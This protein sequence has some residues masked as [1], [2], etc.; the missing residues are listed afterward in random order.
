MMRIGVAFML[1]TLAACAVTEP[2][3][4]PGE[5]VA[6]Q[7]ATVKP[8]PYVPWQGQP[9]P[10]DEHSMQVVVKNGNGYL[11]AVVDTKAFQITWGVTLTSQQEPSYMAVNGRGPIIGP[12]GGP[13]GPCYYGGFSGDCDQ[14]IRLR[15][16]NVMNALG[17]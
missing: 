12:G 6:V 10:L 13:I 1:G 11:A 17:F 4:E 14:F 3:Q 7:E 9:A 16:T 2:G 8:F 15:G 5:D